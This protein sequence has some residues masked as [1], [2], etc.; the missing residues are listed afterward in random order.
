MDEEYNDIEDTLK[1]EDNNG[2]D[3]LLKRVKRI[4]LGIV[5]IY[6]LLSTQKPAT[7]STKSDMHCNEHGVEMVWSQYPSKKSGKKYVYH[8]NAET[9]QRCF[10]RGYLS[11]S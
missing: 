1:A 2:D 3:E 7:T 8:D 4:E 9:G 10:G 5:E 6:K 11:K